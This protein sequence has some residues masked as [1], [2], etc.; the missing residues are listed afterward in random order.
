MLISSP[1]SPDDSYRYGRLLTALSKTDSLAVSAYDGELLHYATHQGKMR[2]LD[3]SDVKLESGKE[4]GRGGTE[5]LDEGDLGE[6]LLLSPGSKGRPNIQAHTQ[7]Q[8]PSAI[9]P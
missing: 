5:G 2:S 4:K 8:V 3:I 7:E 6:T 9:V 1:S